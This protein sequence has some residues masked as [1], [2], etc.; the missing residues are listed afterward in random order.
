MAQTI[1]A[2]A[3]L[4]ASKTGLTIGYR[5]LNLNRTTA[6]AFTTT[7]V[8]E[9]AVDGTYY[10]SGGISA[11]DAGGYIVWGESGTDYAEAP[12]EPAPPTSTALR[13][14][15]DASILAYDPPTKAEL[16]S[17]VSPLMTTAGYTTPPSLVSI[18]AEVD[19]A[20]VDYDPP[21]K[22]EMDTAID[23]IPTAAEINA[24]LVAEHGDDGWGGVNAT[25]DM[26]DYLENTV[27]GYASGTAGNALARL[28]E[29]GELTVVSPIIENSVIS[30]FRGDD[31]LASEGRA[32]DF[33]GT[34]AWPD[35]TGATVT[36]ECAPITAGVNEIE[37]SASVIAGDPV[38]VRVEATSTQTNE[39]SRSGY[40]FYVRAVLASLSV[41]T[42][43]TGRLVV[44]N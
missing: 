20:L 35:L 9:S 26:P 17:A 23:A 3:A 41:V 40:V 13:A 43:A 21:T 16:D 33:T 6:T 32:I 11:P 31:Y 5:I 8:A 2:L 44:R 42:L 15:M 4:G 34:S 18:R 12:I 29:P 22:A 24:L 36:F 14:Q 25:F 30:V 19:D 37:W 27:D 1:P 39:L 38:Q 10:V 28:F 7:N